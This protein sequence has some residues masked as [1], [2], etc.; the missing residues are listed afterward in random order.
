[1]TQPSPQQAEALSR[2]AEL[3]RYSSLDRHVACYRRETDVAATHSSTSLASLTD[4]F[5][6]LPDE[7]QHTAVQQPARRTSHLCQR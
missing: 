4:A 2:C 7:D 3:S 5:L 1:M 6:R